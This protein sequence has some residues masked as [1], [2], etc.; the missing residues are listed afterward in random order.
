MYESINAKRF[1]DGREN[2]EEDFTRRFSSS[3][4]CTNENIERVHDLVQSEESLLKKYLTLFFF[5]YQ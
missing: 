5:F 1:R 4:S 2:V 3:T